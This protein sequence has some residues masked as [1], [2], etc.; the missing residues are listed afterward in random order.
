MSYNFQSPGVY[1][2]EK[3]TFPP[4]VVQVATAIPA[5]IGHT[6]TH[7]TGTE[8][9]VMRVSNFLEFTGSFGGP[10]LMAYT[11]KIANDNV[12]EVTSMMQY[13]LYHSVDLY[14]R[15]GGGP[16]Y[17]VSVGSYQDAVKD[18][19]TPPIGIER[20]LA[21]LERE[22][23][24]TLILLPDATSLDV[25]DCYE[26]YGKALTQAANL[27]DRFVIIDL[28]MSTVASNETDLPGIKDFR[29]KIDTNHVKY[30]AA[31]YPNLVTTL[32][33]RSDEAQITIDADDQNGETRLLSEIA[34]SKTAKDTN[35]HSAIVDRLST[36]RL[37]MPPSAAIAGVYARVDRERGVWKAPANTGLAA[38]IQPTHKITDDEQGRLNVDEAGKSINAIRAFTGKGTLVWGARTLDGNSNEWRYVNVRRLFN[39]IEESIAKA[40]AFAVF[41]ANTA[42]TWLKVKAMI[43]TYLYGLWQAGALAGPTPEASYFVEVGLGKTMTQADVLAGRMIVKIGIA[44]VRPAEFII[45]EFSHK[46]Q[47]A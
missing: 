41:E 27:K 14:F 33:P 23:E 42:S 30:G 31:Y 6:E 19:N 46:L 7:D 10:P 4:S 28:K 3:S 12:T 9:Q 13:H 16:C 39:L 26:M 15:N 45:L 32:R 22:D 17:I 44:A 29:E 47:E 38:V 36:E 24:P 25:D 8:P 2:V 1:T 5:F 21:A 11:V 35:I 40:T 34:K 20:G 37:V 43:E 18:V